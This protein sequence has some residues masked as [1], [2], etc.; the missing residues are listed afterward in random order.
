MTTSSQ[1]VGETSELDFEGKVKIEQVEKMGRAY[2]RDREKHKG[3]QQDVKELDK[4]GSSKSRVWP[5]VGA[6]TE[7]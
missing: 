1:G 5:E 2:S 7:R 6:S 4:V 3:R